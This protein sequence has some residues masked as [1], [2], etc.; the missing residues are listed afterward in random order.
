MDDL[1]SC[2]N[3]CDAFWLFKVSSLAAVS[4]QL[5][6]ADE[7]NHEGFSG[8]LNTD[9][10]L[11]C[12]VFKSRARKLLTDGEVNKQAVGQRAGETA[13]VRMTNVWMS[14]P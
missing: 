13:A 9:R 1:K 6:S 8:H 5:S 10:K 2:N 12:C 11:L 7:I 3:A 4:P 14:P